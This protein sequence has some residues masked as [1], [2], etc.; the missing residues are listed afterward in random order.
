MNTNIE[1]TLYYQMKKVRLAHLR[2]FHEIGKSLKIEG[3]LKW[4]NN[5]FLK[6]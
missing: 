5:I 1:N 3:V 4:L 2:L 6:K